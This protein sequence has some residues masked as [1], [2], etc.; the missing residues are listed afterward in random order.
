M[1]KYILIY[2]LIF[3]SLCLAQESP[4]E[5]IKRLFEDFEYEKV[6]QLSNEL[7]NNKE[8]PDTLRIELHLMRVISF[9][10]FGN[11]DR[12]KQNFQSILELSNGFT[13]DASKISSKIIKLINPRIVTLFNEVKREFLRQ[14]PV[15]ATNPEDVAQIVRF[16]EEKEQKMKWAFLKNSVLPGWGNF[17]INK[18]TKGW[19]TSS[20]SSANF[21]AMLY[22]IIDTNR[23]ENDYLNTTNKQ[24]INQ[25]YSAFNSAFKTRNTLITT[26]ALMWLYNQLDILF[27]SGDGSVQSQNNRFTFSPVLRKTDF[28]LTFKIVF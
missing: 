7:L 28:D 23:K 22:F 10:Y 24:D 15:E 21:I 13:L 5:N 27:F 9:F 4:L 26:Y 8:Y 17:D 16:A 12:V 3:S 11:E 1:T 25:K 20:L 14:N 6:I 19:I 18:S 2:L